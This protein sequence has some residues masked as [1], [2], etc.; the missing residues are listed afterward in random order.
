MRRLIG[1][2]CVVLGVLGLSTGVAQAAR[3]AQHRSPGRVH[4]LRAT[5]RS[6]TSIS[7]SWVVPTTKAHRATVVRYAAGTR[8]PRTAHAGHSAGRLTRSGHT[9]TVG[10]L[11]SGRPYAFSM[12]GK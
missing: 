10:R 2:F 12:A 6:S 3:A 7:L 1:L 8:A 11:R 5:S 4:A 9:L